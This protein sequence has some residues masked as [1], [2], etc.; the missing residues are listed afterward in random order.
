M[1]ELNN[2][3]VGGTGVIYSSFTLGDILS[4]MLLILSIINILYGLVL[5]IYRKVKN[6][7][8]DTIPQEI[9][10]AQELLEKIKNNQEK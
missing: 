3:I 1:Q 2:Y 6:K 9:E 8:F 7:D 5:S 10:N 4:Y